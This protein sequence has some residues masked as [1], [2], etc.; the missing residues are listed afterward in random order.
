MGEN[1]EVRRTGGLE[2]WNEGHGAGAW[3]DWRTG[4][5]EDLELKEDWKTRGL[6]D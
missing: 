2:N 4:G 3:K 1:T 6:E 5:L